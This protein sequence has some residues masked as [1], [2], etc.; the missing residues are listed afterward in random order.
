[1]VRSVAVAI[2]D[3]PGEFAENVSLKLASPLAS[4]FTSVE[5]TKVWPSPLPRSQAS[6]EKNFADLLR[7]PVRWA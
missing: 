7:A 1:V 2:T 6:L 4:V 3:R 5:L